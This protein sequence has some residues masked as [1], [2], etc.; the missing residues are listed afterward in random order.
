MDKG[1]RRAFD[2][3][4][5]TYREAARVQAE[6]AVECA[7]LAGGGPLGRV[8]EIGAGCGLLTELLA[9]RTAGPYVALDLSLAMLGALPVPG[10]LRLAADGEAPPLRPGSFD[11]LASASAMQWFVRPEVALPTCLDLLRPGGGFVLALFTE[12]T[13]A[14]P[15]WAARVSG[16]GSFWPL[17]PAGAY[18]SMLA[19]VPGVLLQVEEREYV[20]HFPS[21][22]EALRSLR[23]SG[24]GFGGGRPRPGKARYR[25]FLS[26]Y[27]ERFGGERGLP[28][29]YRAVFFRGSVGR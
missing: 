22:R 8:L 2:R 14:E 4:R 26:A 20:L 29:T 23:R 17:R 6:V 3:A 9:P 7:R 10:V 19:A 12:G 24:A 21:A 1:V 15:A 16:F 25:A 27:E 11:F 28:L 5:D 18:E 13:L